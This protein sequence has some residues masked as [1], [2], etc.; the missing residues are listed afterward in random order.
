MRILFIVHAPSQKK[1]EHIAEIMDM[2]FIGPLEETGLAEYDVFYYGP[3]STQ[4]WIDINWLLFEKC[5]EYKPDLLVIQNGWLPDYWR[6]AN[7]NGLSYPRLITLYL[8]RT[9]LNIKCCVVLCDQSQQSFKVQDNLTRFCDI[10]FTFE[11]EAF[12]KNHTAFPGKYVV[13]NATFRPSLFH[14][15]ATD[16]RQ[17]DVAFAGQVSGYTDRIDGISQLQQNGIPVNIFGGQGY[18]QK[19]LTNQEYAN[20][21][22]KSKITVNWSRHISGKWFQT[23]GRIFEATLAGSLLLSEECEAV[24]RWL[25][26]NIDYVPFKDNTE[27]IEKAK[28]YLAEDKDR[29]QIASCGNKTALATCSAK[30][31]WN[32]MLT[33]IFSES[34]YCEQEAIR[35]LQLNSTP[36]EIATAE[37]LLD[38]LKQCYPREASAVYE[39]LGIM[40]AA[41]TS[42]RIR[43]TSEGSFMGKLKFQLK[44]IKGYQWILLRKLLPAFITRKRL[45]NI[46]SLLKVQ[47]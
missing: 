26:P 25:K 41:Q 6:N 15:N 5:R 32:M 43:F 9:L 11:H 36:N 23:K 28:Y 22:R 47:H 45:S 7:D 38:N 46:I 16:K 4:N 24:N 27:L 14:G 12:F 42:I 30:P 17:Y 3:W 1:Q 29:L 20:S 33:K 19:R 21:F 2:S 34:Q 39:P 18:G 40:K 8:I 10:S 44:P 13:T 35:G 37:Y 31:I